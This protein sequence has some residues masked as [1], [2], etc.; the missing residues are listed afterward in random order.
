VTLLAH[1]I[2]RDDVRQ[3]KGN[4]GVSGLPATVGWRMLGAIPTAGERR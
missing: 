1:V 3:R 2:K 4:A